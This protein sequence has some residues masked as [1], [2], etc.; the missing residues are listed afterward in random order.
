MSGLRRATAKP[1]GAPTL[2]RRTAR[3]STPWWRADL[4][5]R[6]TSREPPRAARGA[7]PQP[8]RGPTHGQRSSSL[9]H[10]MAGDGPP[11]AASVE[12]EA[13]GR[14]RTSLH[15]PCAA[16]A[17]LPGAP[18]A[19]VLGLQ[20]SWPAASTAPRRR[21]RGRPARETGLVT[22]PNI[23]DT[24]IISNVQA[25]KHNLKLARLEL[26]KKPNTSG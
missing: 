17:D 21:H 5:A 11:C 12:G 9:E 19:V 23:Q 20:P 18:H 1:A 13:N 7:P 10:P 14:G 24:V 15:G 8:A 26:I 6:S 16:S 22:S 4:P 2:G 25:T 3:R